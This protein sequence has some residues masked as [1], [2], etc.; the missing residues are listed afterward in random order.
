MYST[1]FDLTNREAHIY[2]LSHFDEPIHINLIEALQ[3]GERAALLKN[4]IPS[5]SVQ[6][7]N[8]RYW[9][10]QAG[11]AATVLVLVGAVLYGLGMLV[12]SLIS[13]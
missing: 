13:R 4:M 2:P 12:Q 11:G 7:A 6:S 9:A 1:A 5:K 3:E 10:T 8:T